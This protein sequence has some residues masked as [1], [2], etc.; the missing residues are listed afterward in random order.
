MHRIHNKSPRGN[1]CV[2]TP[3]LILQPNIKPDKDREAT[4]E[5]RKNKKQQR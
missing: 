5:G 3:V 1:M 2:V 4:T